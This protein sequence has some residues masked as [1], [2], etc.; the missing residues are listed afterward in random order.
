MPNRTPIDEPDDA[1]VW[2][3]ATL[4]I[5]LGNYESVELSIGTSRTVEDSDRATRAMH[6]KLHKEHMSML[7]QRAEEIRALWSND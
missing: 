3:Q 4:K 7:S 2:S 5:N 6:R 1:R